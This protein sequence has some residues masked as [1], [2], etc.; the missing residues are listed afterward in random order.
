MN[1]NTTPRQF[2]TTKLSKQALRV[3]CMLN[4]ILQHDILARIGVTVHAEMAAGIIHA[5]IFAD[6]T[7]THLTLTFILEILPISGDFW[8]ASE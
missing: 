2:L 7:P 6:H 1:I 5:D 8:N 4:E 3:I